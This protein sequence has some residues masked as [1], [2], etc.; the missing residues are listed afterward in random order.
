MS[1]R[2]E[3]ARI[4]TDGAV[5]DDGW[6][7]FEGNR[8][9]AVGQGA[10]PVGDDELVDAAGRWL[11]PGFLDLHS[12]GGGGGA[13]DGGPEAIRAGLAFHRAH[14][15]TRS[16][17][18]LVTAPQEHLVEALRDVAAVA[19]DDPLVLGAHLEGP[20]LAEGHKGAHDPAVLRDP[21][22]AEVAALLDAA[23]GTLRMITI[24]P[25]RAGAEA[26]IRTLLDAGVVVALG[27]TD[28]GYDVV[29]RGFAAGATVL[30]HAY[31]GMADL[32]HRDPGPVGA[33][34]DSPGV[35][36]ELIA[37]GVHVHDAASRVLFASAPGRVALIT[38]AIAAAG[39][40]DGR[41]VLGGLDVVVQDG[42]A[43]LAEGGSLAGSTLTLDAALRRA[44]QSIRVPMPVAVAAVTSTPA[45]ALGLDDELGRLAPGYAAD[46]VL[47]DDDL[48]V[49]AVWAAGERL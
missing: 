24:A 49:A 37:D 3:H 25:E 44:V 34:L 26:A 13:Y 33:A 16:V 20:F 39:Q 27:H 30:T 11:T 9:S 8:V 38:D 17:L 45:R 36:L 7:R 18:S 2:I 43:R 5:L 32:L 41:Y 31:N 46:A 28:A 6:V 29:R 15:T 23:G 19:A 4:V 21:D 14:G 22:P 47:L 48:S 12:H 10:A 35:T 40:A 1:I 42:E